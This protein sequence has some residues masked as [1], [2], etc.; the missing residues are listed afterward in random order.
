MDDHA[1]NL[2][3][4]TIIATLIILFGLTWTPQGLGKRVVSRFSI[5]GLRISDICLKNLLIA[6]VRSHLKPR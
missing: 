2:W 4:W 5:P 3:P 6:Y 1:G